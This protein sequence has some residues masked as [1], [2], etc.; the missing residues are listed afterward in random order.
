MMMNRNDAIID[1][2][3]SLSGHALADIMERLGDYTCEFTNSTWSPMEEFN[4]CFDG[5]APIEVAE[6]VSNGD[7]DITDDYFRCEFGS[8][9]SCTTAQRSS[10]AEYFDDDIA[11]YLVRYGN[12]DIDT[13][14]EILNRLVH[15]P[16]TAM[17]NENYEMI[18]R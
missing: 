6:I 8:I 16:E 15:A 2:V 3:E 1:Y 18:A 4:N 5:Y 11:D 7:F 9:E 10:E 14:D 12:A 17:F 13:G